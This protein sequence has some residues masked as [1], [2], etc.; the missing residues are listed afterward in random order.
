MAK[1]RYVQIN[2][3]KPEMVEAYRNAHETMHL[4][5]WK[6]QMDVLQKAGAEE[7]I[8]YLYKN[9]SVMIYVCDDIGE[10]FAALGRDPRRVAWDQFTGPMFANDPKFDGS[11]KIEYLHKIFD[12]KEQLHGE[13]TD[14]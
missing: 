7:C 4:G 9:W 5:P 10:S 13:K 12:L 2:E 8:V 1:R 6:E 11:G 3:L 14:F